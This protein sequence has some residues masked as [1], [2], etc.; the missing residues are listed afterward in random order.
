MSDP[1]GTGEREEVHR[2]L[3]A[4]VC[5][6]DHR[7]RSVAVVGGTEIVPQQSTRSVEALQCGNNSGELLE[8]LL[9]RPVLDVRIPGHDDHLGVG[10]ENVLA[11][12][13]HVKIDQVSHRDRLQAN[14]MVEA[15]EMIPTQIVAVSMRYARTLAK[16]EPWVPPIYMPIIPFPEWLQM[17]SCLRFNWAYG[18]VS[19]LQYSRSPRRGSSRGPRRERFPE[20]PMADP[21]DLDRTHAVRKRHG[22]RVR[23]DRCPRRKYL[24]FGDGEDRGRKCRWSMCRCLDHAEPSKTECEAQRMQ[25]EVVAVSQVQIHQAGMYRNI[26]DVHIQPPRA[27][28]SPAD[29]S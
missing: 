12:P 8:V 13:G 9:A 10:F 21:T 3:G 23:L 18:L 22:I 27:L 1:S 28:D 25:A 14:G 17:L 29:L 26:R 11:V 15:E 4:E 7:P 5:S 20:T 16:D 2:S 6:P 19:R 24:D